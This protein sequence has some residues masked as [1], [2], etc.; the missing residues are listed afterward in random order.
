[1]LIKSFIK[2]R[3]KSCIKSFIKLNKSLGSYQYVPWRVLLLGGVRFDST[4]SAYQKED[5][6]LTLACPLLN[7]G[8][9]PGCRGPQGLN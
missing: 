1:M 6:L 4:I 5:C 7:P 8:L 9:D 3:I 2:S